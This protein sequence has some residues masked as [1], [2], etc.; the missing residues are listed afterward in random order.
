MDTVFWLPL[1]VTLSLR[2]CYTQILGYRHDYDPLVL[3]AGDASPATAAGAYQNSQFF[4][5]PESKRKQGEYE[6]YLRSTLADAHLTLS[7]WLSH[8]SNGAQ[9]VQGLPQSDDAASR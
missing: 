6:I 7:P 4:T 2:L 3:Q 9:S 1:N 8:L 5:W